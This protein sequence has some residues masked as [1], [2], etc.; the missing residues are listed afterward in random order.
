M[1]RILIIMHFLWR[2]LFPVKF[3]YLVKIVGLINIFWSTGYGLNVC[4][5][6]KMHMLKSEPLMVLGGGALGSRL[7]HEGRAPENGISASRRRHRRAFFSLSLLSTMWGHS[8]KVAVCQSGREPSPDTW[9]AGTL[10]LDFPASRIVR[11]RQ[12]LFK[13]PSLWQ[14]VVAAWAETYLILAK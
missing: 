10:I 3:D 4:V 14:L 5:T 13:A 11:N 8:Q 6:P 9:S 12:V 2:Y 7:G 1:S